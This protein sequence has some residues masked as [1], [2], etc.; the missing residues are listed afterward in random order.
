MGSKVAKSVDLLPMVPRESLSD[1]RRLVKDARSAVLTAVNVG[2]TM[3]YW[4]IDK[5]S[6]RKS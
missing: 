6:T 3:L 4:R 2:L 5:R 1:I